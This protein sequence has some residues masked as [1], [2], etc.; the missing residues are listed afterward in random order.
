MKPITSIRGH[1]EILKILQIALFCD[2]FQ[3]RKQFF[4]RWILFIFLTRCE[5]DRVTIE[6]RHSN[7]FTHEPLWVMNVHRLD[8]CYLSLTG[9]YKLKYERKNKEDSGPSS[10]MTSSCNGLLTKN[11]FFSTQRI[12]ISAHN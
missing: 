10:K 1:Y 6:M 12:T 11:S 9:I 4:H 3:K 5:L 7:S 8:F 2:V